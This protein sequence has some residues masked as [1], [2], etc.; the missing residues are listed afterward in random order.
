LIRQIAIIIFIMSAFPL[1]VGMKA[2]VTQEYLRGGS[3]RDPRRPGADLY[4]NDAVSMG[5]KWAAAGAILTLGSVLLFWY[6]HNHRR[7]E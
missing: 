2:M 1:F 7:E 6:G 3:F 4:G 5:R